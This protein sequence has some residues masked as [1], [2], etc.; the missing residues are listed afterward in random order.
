MVSKRQRALLG[1]LL[2]ALG[3]LTIGQSLGLLERPPE[4]VEA[5]LYTGGDPCY[6]TGVV[7]RQ[8]TVITAETAGNWVPQAD[9]GQR[10]AAGQTILAWETPQ[11]VAAAMSGLYVVRL[12]LEAAETPLTVRRNQ[13]RRDI[14]DLAAADGQDRRALSE[15]LTGLLLSE[16]GDLEAR[17]ARAEETLLARS[18]A[19]TETISAPQAG[20]FAAA[21]DGLE[22]ILTPED[23]WAVWALPLPTADSRAVGRLITGDC[24]YFRTA[25]T[26]SPQVGDTLTAR[27][28]DGSRETLELTVEEIRDGQVLLR[29]GSAL[30]RVASVRTMTIEILPETETGVE[31]PAQS[32]YT[33]DGETGVWC[34]V[35][36]SAVFKAVTIRK[37]LGETVVAELDQSTTGTLWPGDLVLVNGQ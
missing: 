5:L 33:L 6:A 22:D 18:T 34:L 27:L 26:E 7:I 11:T 2:A 36:E 25:L 29:C 37:D 28:L 13:L 16:T 30:G 20:I 24:W 1:A 14:S 12:G 32:V 8:E 35:G 19:A 3:A 23:P 4:T 21:V 17:L 10:V 31:I 9:D 15:A